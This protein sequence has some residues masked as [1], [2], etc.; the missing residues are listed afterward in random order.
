MSDEATITYDAITSVF[1]LRVVADIVEVQKREHRIQTNEYLT[2]GVLPIIDQSTAPIAGY[3]ADL[4]RAYAG[5]LPI[6]VFGDHTC[7]YKFINFRFAVGADG[8]QLL[9]GVPG[10]DTRYL[11]YALHTSTVKQFGYQRHFKLLKQSKI[12][13]PADVPVQRRIASILGAYDDLIDVN[14]RRIAVLEEMARRLFEEWFV[15][16]RFPGLGAEQATSADHS[17]VPLGWSVRTVGSF[18]SVITGKTPSKANPAFYGNDVPFVKTPDLHGNM[19]IHS[20]YECLSNEGA[21]SQQNKTIPPRSLVVSCIGTV[22]LVSITTSS[23]QTN[24]QINSVV[25]S[26]PSTLE[27]LYFRLQDAKKALENLGSNG[28]TMANVNKSK[29]ESLPVL[30]PPRELIERFHEMTTTLFSLIERLSRGC[31]T[32]TS[33]RDL[34]LPRLISGE[35][36]IAAAEREVEAVA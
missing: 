4:K 17:R 13:V 19:F 34:L 3:L 5:P 9:T 25:L 10:V 31:S 32:L 7:I 35:L 27:F 6:V 8:T 26:D 23:C 20:T 1:P 11:Y 30:V 12:P 14:R 36:A 18:G 33:S 2:T 16:F 15:H 28:A 21:V 24:Q 29:F 22:G